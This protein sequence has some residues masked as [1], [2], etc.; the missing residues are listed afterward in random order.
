MIDG[1]LVRILI[2]KEEFSCPVIAGSVDQA[3]FLLS[4]PGQLE[5]DIL[6]FL[7]LLNIITRLFHVLFAGNSEGM[8]AIKLEIKSSVRMKLVIANRKLNIHSVGHENLT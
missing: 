3:V 4:I 1:Y 6:P 7:R 5:E 8:P 2:S